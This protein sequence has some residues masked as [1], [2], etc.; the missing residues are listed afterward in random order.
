M[1][2]SDRVFAPEELVEMGKRACDIRVDNHLM[3]DEDIAVVMRWV[4]DL[5]PDVKFVGD[6]LIY[7]PTAIDLM[8]FVTASVFPEFYRRHELGKRD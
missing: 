3:S 1:E 8:L 7:G 2:I 5:A 4:G 6:R